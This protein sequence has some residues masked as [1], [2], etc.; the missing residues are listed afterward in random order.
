MVLGGLAAAVTAAEAGASVTLHE[1][2]RTLGG[3]WRSTPGKEGD[4]NPGQRP[5]PVSS[6]R[7]TPCDLSRRAHL[8]LAEGTP[9]AWRHL[10]SAFERGN[11]FPFWHEGR[12]RRVP[13][14]A[15]FEC[16]GYHAATTYQLINR[17]VRGRQ[18][19]SARRRRKWALRSGVGIF[20]R[21]P[22]R[23]R[24]RFVAERLSRCTPSRPRPRIVRAAGERCSRRSG[25][26]PAGLG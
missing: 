2:H 24:Q 10:P 12:V 16:C 5:P 19:S 25:R 21:D 1:A 9:P 3:R 8:G 6:A 14:M 7:R 4:A 13:P 22:A 20:H 18:G 11:A 17:S 23:C 15:S 26:T